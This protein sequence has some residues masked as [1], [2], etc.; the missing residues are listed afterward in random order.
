MKYM[1]FNSLISLAGVIKEKLSNVT[2]QI[3]T[4]SNLLTTAKSNLVSAINEIHDSQADFETTVN[5]QISAVNSNLANK[6]NTSDIANNLTTTSSGKVL[7]ARQGKTLSDQI[8]GKLS[9]SNIANNLTTT[10]S[11]YALDA[12]QG[13]ALNDKF[14]SYYTKSQTDSKVNGRL[15]TSGGTVSG[16]L[17]LS[18]ALHTS[19]QIY[20]AYGKSILWNNSGRIYCSAHQQMYLS[21]STEGKYFLHLGVHDNTWALDPDTNGMLDLGTPNHK[22]SDIYATNGSIQTSDRTL[23]NSIQDPD[24]RYEQLFM[25]LRPKSFKFNGGTS[26]RTHIGFISQDVE[27]AMDDVGLDS[28]EFAG[29]CKDQKTVPVEVTKQ[30]EVYD[31]D[32][33]ETEN[34]E[35]AYMED[36]PVEGEYVYSLRYEEFIALNTM[37]I[38]QLIQRVEELEKKLA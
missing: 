15:S 29:F 7:D 25:H 31:Q 14:G 33:G 8:S 37:M 23:K 35:V 10:S 30:V 2:S 4:L 3:G 9:T 36:K 6:V 16:D 1:S 11:G 18:K 21:A 34:Q 24:E 27:E 26:G 32:T 22:W 17:T 28:L 5:S 38:Q 19:G 12:R 13:K 20:M